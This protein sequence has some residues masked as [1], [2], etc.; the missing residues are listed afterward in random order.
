MTHLPVGQPE[1][2][3]NVSVSVETHAAI[4]KFE[5]RERHCGIE[6]VLVNVVAWAGV[7]EQHVTLNVA[8]RQSSQPC[9]SIVADCVDRP[10]H[11]CG[12]VVVE[13]F[14]DLRVR[15]G[16]VVITNK[17]EPAPPSDLI[18][19]ALGVAPISDHIAEAQG[20]IGRRA[21]AYDRLQRLPVGVDV[22][23]DRDLQA[24]FPYS[25]G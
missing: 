23:E 1:Y 13:P 2:A 22:R 19:A 9:D 6:D 10:S 11:H 25:R 12:G 18:D 3:G 5:V 17:G 16:S 21:I 24:G 15:A 4:Q 8:V 14:E 7:D 20:L